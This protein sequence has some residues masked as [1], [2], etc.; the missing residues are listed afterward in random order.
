MQN[1]V[2]FAHLD[3]LVGV[4]IREQVSEKKEILESPEARYRYCGHESHSATH[5]TDDT[6]FEGKGQTLAFE[7]YSCILF[8]NDSGYAVGFQ[9]SKIL[10]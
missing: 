1:A 2:D 10:F 6:K 8:V 9:C 4:R 7:L 5:H 3:Y